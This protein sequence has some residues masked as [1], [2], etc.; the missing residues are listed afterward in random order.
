MSILVPCYTK[1]VTLNEVPDK[2][3]VYF[4]LGNCMQN[5]KGCHSPHLQF[6][7]VYKPLS[8][9]SDLLLYAEEQ[10]E[11]GANAIVIM[12]GH[13][14][15][16]FSADKLKILIDKMAEIAPVCLYVGSDDDK[17]NKEIFEDTELTWLK[18]G[19]YQQDKGGL[20][21]KKTNQ[22]FYKKEMSWKTVGGVLCHT[23]GVMDDI[24]YKFQNRGES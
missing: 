1:G 16:I 8:Y 6:D 23:E 22:R 3:A 21:C 17:F 12:G 4:E 13:N 20:D 15:A 10:V 24:T 2:I 14:N 18:T 11:N 7:N 5:C 9:L 19:S